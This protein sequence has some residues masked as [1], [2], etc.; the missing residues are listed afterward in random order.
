MAEA[1]VFITSGPYRIVRHP[2]YVGEILAITALFVLVPSWG[3][4]VIFVAF[5]I[6]QGTRAFVEQRK[7]SAAFPEYEEYRER[8]GMFFPRLRVRRSRSPQ[9]QP[10]PQPAD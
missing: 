7:L 2:V 10:K 6:A 4:I 3:G 8:T 1:R 5:I 9:L